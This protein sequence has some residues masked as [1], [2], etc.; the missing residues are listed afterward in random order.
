MGV[1]V[2]R[3]S[4]FEFG[5]YG[6]GIEGHSLLMLPGFLTDISSSMNSVL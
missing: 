4:G 5:L 2:Y 6:L 1:T 3:L